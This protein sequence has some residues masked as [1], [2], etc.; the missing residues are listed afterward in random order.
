M[1]NAYR[2][3]GLNSNNPRNPFSTL[4]RALTRLMSGPIDTWRTQSPRQLKRWQLE[5]YK[6]RFRSAQGQLF[7]QSAYNP[8]EHLYLRSIAYQNRAERYIDFDQM[9]FVPEVSTALDIYAD[10]MTV[11][12]PLTPMI[13]IKSSNQEV[14]EIIENLLYDTLNIEHNL[15]GWC[16]T[17][18]K[19]GDFFLYLDIDEQFGITH[20][21][22]LPAEELERLE[23]EDPTNPNY[24]QFQW[25]SAGLTLENWQ[26]A[27]FR[28]L[29]NDKYAPYGSCHKYDT[30]IYTETGIKEI[31]DIKKNDTVLTFDLKTQSFVPTKV[32]D[33]VASG[34]K[35]C[36]NIRTKHNFLETSKEHLILVFDKEKGFIYKN[37]LE[38]EI[39][40]ILVISKKHSTN[41]KIKINKE[42]PNGKNFNGFWNN[43]N[44][45][46]N[47]INEDFARLFGFLLGDG[48]LPKRNKQVCFA[49]SEYDEINE[50]YISL[51]EKFS[52]K[53]AKSLFSKKHHNGY[54]VHSKMLYI[55]LKRLG[56]EGKAT[57]KRLPEWVFSCSNEIKEALLKGLHDANGSL[58]VDKWGCHR[59][60][61]ELANEQL[62]KDVKILLQTLG[63]K[64]GKI[65]SRKRTPNIIEGRQIKEVQKSFY[66]Y[67]YDSQIE[68]SKKYDN[69]E[70]INNDYVL[71]P[72]ISIEKSGKF[73]TYDIYVENEN[74]NFIANGIITHNSVLDPAR[75]I[76]RQLDLLEQAMMAYRVVRSAERRVF[77]LDVAGISADKVEEYLEQQI[78]QYKRR[79]VTDDDE[80]RVDLRYKPEAVDMDFFIPVR[81]QNSATR[82]DTLKGG[83]YTGD[84]DDVKYLRDKLF[85]ALKIPAEYL[86][87]YAGEGGDLD[88]ATL[89]QK[90]VRFARTI[91]RLQKSVVSELTK[92][93]VTHLFI[94]GY[95]G[96]DL[97]SF[98]LSLN[99]PSKIAELQE[100]EQWRTKFEVAGQAV[101][102][103]FSRRWI[104]KNLFGLTDEEIL[105]NQRELFYDRKMD[106]MLEATIET[107]EIE[108]GGG[109]AFEMGEEPGGGETAGEEETNDETEEDKGPLL[110]A[111]G[112][113]RE[114]TTT[115]KSKGKV[116]HPV[117]TD[118]RNMGARRR[119]YLKQSGDSKA[120]GGK[121]NVFPGKSELDTLASGLFEEQ[122][123]L[124][125]PSS[126][127]KDD[128][129]DL[130][131]ENYEVKMLMESLSTI[132]NERK[133]QPIILE[134]K[135]TDEDK[136][137]E[138]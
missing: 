19:Y 130:L 14:K 128:E 94:L 32:L 75:R 88:K 6:S 21:M 39:N 7:K 36:Y 112:H 41:K 97:T 63:R 73:K 104:G 35:T 22:G 30:R 67:Y 96:K 131:K 68:Q 45:I 114:G 93:C 50:Y 51:L 111:P 52:G 118:K 83:Q 38:L 77:Y 119:S 29:G 120:E 31:K 1:A 135:I 12:S 57:T 72:I 49:K 115:P 62:I 15:F 134:H 136:S 3:T 42:Q 99:T 53:K 101:E 4:Y 124:W 126:Y 121:R 103:F 23:G 44:N 46:P 2:K 47:E 79:Q 34:K 122:E 117:K 5:K 58:F 18:C 11:S 13:H 28:I 71:E 65:S 138:E 113:R 84:I 16:R 69:F 132:N 105:Q 48:W 61:L 89:A 74:H 26:V 116:Y 102:G 37:T 17:M 60:S 64:T 43:I 109:G 133:K 108:A 86:S 127:E 55:I 87:S 70:K 54:C 92:M 66:F 106:A 78:T 82:V 10:E 129:E 137:G 24:V 8:F 110:A 9:E 123:R 90:D 98:K 91:G 81:G 107:T 59:Y 95:R 100:L 20:A 80:G 76:F 40:D 125:N 56:F 27:H 25:N 85:T 33:T